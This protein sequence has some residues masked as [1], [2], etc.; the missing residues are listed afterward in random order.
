MDLNIWAQSFS[1]AFNRFWTEVAGFL[2]NLIAT[3][4]VVLFGLFVSK[5]LT[6]WVAKLLEKLL[7]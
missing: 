3:V 5:V 2:P 6:K 4:I 1:N 7:L